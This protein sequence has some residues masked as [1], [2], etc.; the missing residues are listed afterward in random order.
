MQ[1]SI[2]ILSWVTIDILIDQHAQNYK[3][4]CL[5]CTVNLN[6]FFF[7]R[8]TI[9]IRSEFGYIFQMPEQK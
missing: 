1:S 6:V 4:L 8:G 2:M 7:F 5:R 3:S 9:F